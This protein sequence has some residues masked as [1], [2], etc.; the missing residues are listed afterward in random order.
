MLFKHTFNFLCGLSD[1]NKLAQLRYGEEE[2]R[3]DD[4]VNLDIN[5]L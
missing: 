5:M 2:S 1:R 3:K 4:H